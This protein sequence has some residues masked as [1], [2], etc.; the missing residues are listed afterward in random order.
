MTDAYK[1]SPECP[2]WIKFRTDLVPNGPSVPY[3]D[4]PLHEWPEG[5]APLYDTVHEPPTTPRQLHVAYTSTDDATGR[6]VRRSRLLEELPA[7]C[8]VGAL[9]ALLHELLGT[10]PRQPLDVQYWGRSL[11]DESRLLKEYAL[12]E[13]SEVNVVVAA[14]EGRRRVPGIAFA[15]ARRARAPRRRGARGAARRRARRSRRGDHGGRAPPGRGDSLRAPRRGRRAGRQRPRALRGR[16][17][18]ARRAPLSGFALVEDEKL[19]VD[20]APPGWAAAAAPAREKKEG[21]KKKK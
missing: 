17:P 4:E 3:R 10:S 20:W 16:R 21:G 1:L 14:A 5:E 13:H 15:A 12:K 9:K 6:L 2:S 19:F 11:D 18:R 7:H 8:S